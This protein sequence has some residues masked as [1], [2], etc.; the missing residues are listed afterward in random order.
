[1]RKLF[2][3]TL[4]LSFY[5]LTAAYD[6]IKIGVVPSENGA[7]YTS[8]LESALGSDARFEFID[9]KMIPEILEEIE[10]RQTGITEEDDTAGMMLKNVNYLVSIGGVDVNSVFFPSVP[11]QYDS[12]TGKKIKEAVPAYYSSSITGNVKI[13]PV[14]EGGSAETYKVSA[15]GT[16]ENK[17]ESVKAAQEQFRRELKTVMMRAF[18]IHAVTDAFTSS[19]FKLLRG[20]SSGVK[21][22]QKY[23]L[24]TTV[25]ENVAGKNYARKI[26]CGFAEI[27][28][29]Q[30]EYST[31]AILFLSDARGQTVDAVERQFSG[32]SFELNTLFLKSR[33][34]SSMKRN[35]GKLDSS[36]GL[37]LFFGGKLQGGYSL[38]AGYCDD[39]FYLTPISLH[40]RYNMHI[41]R[42]LS[43]VSGISGSYNM[44]WTS[45]NIRTKSSKFGGVIDQY[46]NYELDSKTTITGTSLSFKPYIGF[47]ILLS[48][49][50]YSQFLVAY[51][52]ASDYKWK[53]S[54]KT[55]NSVDNSTTS[56]EDAS[57]KDYDNY[58]KKSGPGGFEISGSIGI[59]F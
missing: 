44:A 20:S 58:M 47:R 14:A 19:E 31:A 23:S 37:G 30:D 50:V 42:R 7:V 13:S 4:I 24:F 39:I 1:M 5:A 11:A 6:R 48:E 36:F 29:V 17:G 21:P 43:I 46:G 34:D 33:K 22:G 16:S 28:D 53:F 52:F 25:N 10:K 12:G 55:D 35:I 8:M 49:T 59:N 18:P 26:N 45:V 56:A 15:S 3:V 54:K 51:S 40:L 38:S 27:T 41:Y 9:S 57:I 2:A 32:V